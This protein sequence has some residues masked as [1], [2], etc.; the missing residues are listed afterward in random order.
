MDAF[1]YAHSRYHDTARL[2]TVNY[3]GAF[4][5][6]SS[7]ESR[8]QSDSGA[9]DF[10]PPGKLIK[11]YTSNARSFEIWYGELSDEAVRKLIERMQ[12]FISFFIEAGTP[13]ELDDQEW[14]LQRWNVYFV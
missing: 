3:Q 9:R 10:T 12:I 8:I 2:L 6:L 14:T 4:A 7:Y 11:S 5:S 13:L 1:Q